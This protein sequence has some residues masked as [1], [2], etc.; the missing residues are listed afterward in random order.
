[1]TVKAY[2]RM[3]SGTHSYELFDSVKSTDSIVRQLRRE[4][5]YKHFTN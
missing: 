1:V 2:A 3:L 5:S 4:Q